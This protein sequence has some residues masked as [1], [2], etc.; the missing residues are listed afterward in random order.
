[1]SLNEQQVF[2]KEKYAKDYI[3][4]NSNYVLEGGIKCWAQMLQRAE[5]VECLLE[6]GSNIGKNINILNHVLPTAKKSIIEISP[7]AYKIV[8]GKYELEQSFNGP[9]VESAFDKEQFDLVFT[10]GVLIHIH[11]DDLLAN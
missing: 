6:C 1:M 7:D 10:M 5:K 3:S 11:P 4:K 2:W 9:I 8:T